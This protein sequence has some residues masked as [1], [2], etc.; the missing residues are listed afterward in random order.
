MSRL[1]EMNCE[2]M[3]G[4]TGGFAILGVTITASLIGKAIVALGAASGVAWATNEALEKIA[5]DNSY[6]KAYE[7]EMER[8]NSL[9]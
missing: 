1:S 9:Q 3:L 7:A 6:E 5:Y 4:V 2:E 8:L